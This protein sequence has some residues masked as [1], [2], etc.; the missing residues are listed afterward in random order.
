M[1]A[2]W[3]LEEACLWIV[4]G[5]LDAVNRFAKDRS[6]FEASDNFTHHW[7]AE[8]GLPDD[9][10][11]PRAPDAWGASKLLL[12]ACGA[13]DI[14]IY[15]RPYGDGEAE[16]IPPHE[17]ASAE[18]KHTTEPD[19]LEVRPRRASVNSKW[20]GLLRVRVEDV[21]GL[22]DP[23]GSRE[24]TSAP[25][26]NIHARA[27]LSA[28]KHTPEKPPPD[29]FTAWALAER[30]QRLITYGNA[31]AAMTEILRR[32]PGRNELR[33]WLKTVKSEWKA[34]RGTPPPER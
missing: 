2:W 9:S 19:G 21:Q 6:L 29:E 3:T 22:W 20:W 12:A 18:F 11:D 16:P 25:V 5:D 13:G 30:L 24:A 8:R 23:N 4:S 33:R 10:D 26:A 17:C 15:G 31:K 32:E 1:S 28:K 27:S 34:V 14:E 7:Q